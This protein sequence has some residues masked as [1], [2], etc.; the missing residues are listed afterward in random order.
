LPLSQ[1]PQRVLRF[2]L[3]ELGGGA[4]VHY[5]ARAR[6]RRALDACAHACAQIP[7]PHL[8]ARTLVVVVVVVVVVIVV[9]VVVVVFVVVVVL[10]VVVVVVVAVAAAAV[11]VAVA[12]AAAA[13]VLVAALF[14]PLSRR[15]FART[16]S[17]TACTT[18][19][20][21]GYCRRRLPTARSRRSSWRRNRTTT[22]PSCCR[23]P[24]W[25]TLATAQ[26]KSTTSLVRAV[27]V[28]ACVLMVTAE[29]LPVTA[30][31]ACAV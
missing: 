16:S 13:A 17:S 21:S 15:R 18:S 3:R 5:L 11:A 30:A 26:T 1:K 10:V 24:C 9:V 14:L 12:V 25:W 27:R 23:P 22:M 19:W 28:R 8:R 29:S 4:C 7:R 2:C 20:T 31:A 6:Q